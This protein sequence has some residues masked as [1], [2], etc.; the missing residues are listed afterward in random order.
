MIRRAEQDRE[1]CGHDMDH[2]LDVARIA[3]IENLER[4]LGLKK[5][6]IYAAALLHDIGRASQYRDGVP[7]DE[8]GREIAE[9]LLPECGFTAMETE[10][11]S[12]AIAGHRL[13]TSALQEEEADH[14]S[15]LAQVLKRADHRAR[16]CYACQ[17]AH[18]C[19]WPHEKKN[20][21]IEI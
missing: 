8:A 5:E 18:T 12:L 7:H 16:K 3:W 11:I 4:K 2:F 17:A 13:H 6:M 9:K 19:Y 15:A 14:A 10:E 1:Y 21:N 20:L